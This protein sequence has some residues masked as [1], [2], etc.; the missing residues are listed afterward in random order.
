MSLKEMLLAD[1]RLK[2]LGRTLKLNSQFWLPLL[3]TVTDVEVLTP[4]SCEL[5]PSFTSDK[6]R[7]ALAPKS[8]SATL[9]FNRIF[10]FLPP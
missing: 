6:S 10:S 1:R 2:L 9:R 3:E 7:L 5:P 8:L 4:L